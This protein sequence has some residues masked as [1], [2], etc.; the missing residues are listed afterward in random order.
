[1]TDL[2][3]PTAAARPASPAAGLARAAAV[4]GGAQALVLAAGLA[5]AKLL[6]MG[7]GPAQFGLL[8]V[9]LAAQGALAT[10]AA[11]GLPSAA[12]RMAAARPRRLP[13][14]ARLLP[15]AAALQGALACA[16]AILLREPLSILL[17]G[18]P[19]HADL[20]AVAALGLPLAAVGAVGA[21]LLQGR[22]RM[23]RL[24]AARVGAAVLGL[25]GAGAALALE[26]PLP[27]LLLLPPLCLAAAT[28]ATRP[29][30]GLPPPRAPARRLWRPLLGLGLAVTAGAATS[31]AALVALR[32]HVAASL[33]LEAAGLLAA[34]WTLAVT[35]GGFALAALAADGYPRLAAAAARPAEARGL[36]TALTVLALACAGPVL[37][38]LA[39]HPGPVLAWLYDAPF[40][41]GGEALAWMAAG[42]VPRLP[43]WAIALAMLAAGAGRTFL[44]LELLF[45][46][47]CVALSVALM[48]AWGLAA[49]GLAYAVAYGAYLLAALAWARRRGL[50]PG[51]GAW[52]LAAAAGAGCL[53]AIAWPGAALALAAAQAALGLLVL[54]RRP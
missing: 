40:R 51:A 13:R 21:G 19:E 26:A 39:G 32:A 44:A 30:G 36:V 15:R 5:R 18:G 52:V 23:R 14:L 22:R 33:G 17:L 35:Q 38:L 25:A 47:A 12:V 34:A 37:V 54:W 1:M 24:A 11:L 3:V 46:T 10:W 43:G 53:G 45:A 20:V 16:T 41:A 4:I 27:A 50:V 8:S 49:V 9:L 48:P 28:W 2:P 29:A 31:V 6:A 7:L 42:S